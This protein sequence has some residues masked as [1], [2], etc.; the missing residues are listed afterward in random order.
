MKNV[1]SIAI[2]LSGG[3]S[4]VFLVWHLASTKAQQS[5]VFDGTFDPIAQSIEQ[6]D[7][8]TTGRAKHQNPDLFPSRRG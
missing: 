4:G 2:I 7:R 1:A 5:L 3:V 6:M 8:Q